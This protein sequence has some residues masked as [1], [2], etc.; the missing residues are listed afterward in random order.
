MKYGEPF[1]ETSESLQSY[2][3][4]YCA[5]VCGDVA[6]ADASVI[7]FCGLTSAHMMLYR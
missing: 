7:L 1:F 4:D 2:P 6:C 3:N 5:Y